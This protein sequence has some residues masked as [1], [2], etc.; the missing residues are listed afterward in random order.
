M[1]VMNLKEVKVEVVQGEL[2]LK[3][4]EDCLGFC[5]QSK[6][7]RMNLSGSGS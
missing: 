5:E 2:L 7:L 4:T 6:K 3:K 1:E